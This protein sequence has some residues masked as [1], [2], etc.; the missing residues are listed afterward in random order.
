MYLPQ[1]LDIATLVFS[2]GLVSLL[3]ALALTGYARRFP[4]FR[5]V[6][7]LAGA[8]VTLALAMS[9]MASRGPE[10]SGF[11]LL[12]VH[13]LLLGA[14]LLNH[15]G[16]RRFVGLPWA[17]AGSPHWAML[18]LLVALGW[19]SGSAPAAASPGVIASLCAGYVTA[20][21]AWVLYRGPVQ[22]APPRMRLT[23]AVFAGFSLLHG[24]G[25]VA[26]VVAPTGAGG[27]SGG[28]TGPLTL[29]G[30]TAFVLLKN[31]SFLQASTRA[32]I[33]EM[34]RQARTDPLTGLLNRRAVM[35]QGVIELS[36]ARRQ[37][38]PLSVIL[39]DIDH[40]KAINDGYGHKVGDSALVRMGRLLMAQTRAFDLRARYAGEE[41]MVLLPGTPLAIAVQVAEKLRVALAAEAWPELDGRRTTAS[42]GVAGY[43]D[44]DSLQDLIA[45]A[46][47]ALRT[48]KK[49]G[50]NRV[51]SIDS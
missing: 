27:L 35:E 5:G 45:S 8:D 41:F 13:G 19:V 42:F 2:T 12:L 20:F 6:L 29:V 14:L 32:L 11:G 44:H 25:A 46:D 39:V 26:G 40:F 28:W 4:Q 37:S 1:Q 18:V 30:T 47:R 23:A 51:E 48:A 9:L 34:S 33:E 7:W 10:Q 49:S 36:R 31:Y 43:A 16:A 24:V 22:A 38:V 21:T 50:R 15:E 17:R 3:F